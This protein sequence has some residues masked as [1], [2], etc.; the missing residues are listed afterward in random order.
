MSRGPSLLVARVHR[1]GRAQTCLARNREEK[2]MSDSLAAQ[3]ICRAYV[4]LVAS[5]IRS[6]AMLNAGRP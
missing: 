3:T 2:M 4:A 5:V 6:F 1:R